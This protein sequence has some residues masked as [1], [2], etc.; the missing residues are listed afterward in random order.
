MFNTLT[1]LNEEAIDHSRYKRV[2]GNKEQNASNVTE[3][4]DYNIVEMS[5]LLKTSG[6]KNSN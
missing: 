2:P 6:N 3:M 4:S 1:A 5:D